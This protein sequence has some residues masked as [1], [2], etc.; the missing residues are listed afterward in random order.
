IRAGFDPAM[1]RLR[2]A[3]QK[4]M[5]KS[6]E[7]LTSLAQE[8]GGR[9]FVP[10]SGDE[11]ISEGSEVARDIGAQYL[12]TYRPKRSLAAAPRDEYRRLTVAPRRSGLLVRK[13]RGYLV[14]TGP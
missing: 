2:N 13:R 5:Q 9:L 6:E 4:A 7:R 12:I 11:M 3:Y 1:K 10:T 8:T 14:S